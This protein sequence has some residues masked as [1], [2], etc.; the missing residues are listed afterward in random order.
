[1]K[2]RTQLPDSRGIYTQPKLIDRSVHLGAAP[3]IAAHEF[4]GRAR[5]QAPRLIS[6]WLE[7]ASVAAPQGGEQVRAGIIARALRQIPGLADVQI[8]DGPAGEGPNVYARLPGT[9]KGSKIAVISTL[10]DLETIAALRRQ[11][12]MHL[13]R[14]GD[15]LI[16]PCV[17]TASISASATAVARLLCGLDWRPAGDVLFACVSGEE[18]GLTGMQRFLA[19][20]PGEIDVVIEILGGVGTVSHGTIGADWLDVRLSAEPRHS[21]SGGR[22]AITEALARIALAVGELTPPAD[23]SGHWSVL[24]V[25]TMRAGTVVNHSPADGELTIDIRSTDRDWLTA[26]RERVCHLVARLAA[27]YEVAVR[28]AGLRSN[29][30]LPLAGGSDNPLVRAAADAIAATGHEPVIRPWSSSNLGVAI[31]AGLP[32][33]AM[34]GTIRGGARGAEQEWCGI[35]GVISG[36]AASAALIS[37][38]STVA[39]GTG[40]I[41]SQ[42]R[43]E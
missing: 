6:D 18:T 42:R 39:D 24:R 17:N 37:R 36:V 19:G 15:R 8:S 5:S 20:R 4:T 33:V 25:N 13:R 1:L 10:D 38:V 2:V 22:A 40:H 41:G 26:T 14:D 29:P 3:L 32:G 43:P 27:E 7:I 16:G 35:E 31:E 23:A 12:G 11:P 9:S 30:P 28:V 21:L 34:E